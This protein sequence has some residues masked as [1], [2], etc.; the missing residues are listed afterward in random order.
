MS[1]QASHHCENLGKV[2]AYTVY[3]LGVTIIVGL[4]R[5]LI[6]IAYIAMHII[7]ANAYAA[8][9]KKEANARFDHHVDKQVAR[10][11]ENRKA[12]QETRLAKGLLDTAKAKAHEVKTKLGNKMGELKDE[13]KYEANETFLEAQNEFS[14]KSEFVRQE[15][16]Y[17]QLVRGLSEMVYIGAPYY[18]YQD[19][20][21]KDHK[22][23]V[24]G[25]QELKALLRNE[26][27]FDRMVASLSNKTAK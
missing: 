18:T 6:A 22:A 10:D 9:Y 17:G 24:Y 3:N 2:V 1:V 11:R 4:V 21:S 14:Q 19:N 12:E 7:Y 20:F 25:F 13:I 5:T 8:A 26:R 15:E 27:D 23:S 16:W